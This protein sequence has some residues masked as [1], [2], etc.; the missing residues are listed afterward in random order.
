MREALDVDT[1]LDDADVS[2]DVSGPTRT[3]F[4]PN[5]MTSAKQQTLIRE[6]ACRKRGRPV[7]TGEYAHKKRYLLLK[8]KAD[9]LATQESINDP[10][11]EEGSCEDR[12]GGSRL[13]VGR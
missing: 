5:G 10:G 3:E 7:T 2:S 11:R 1:D 4:L 13:I 6:V 9:L 8:E 12:E